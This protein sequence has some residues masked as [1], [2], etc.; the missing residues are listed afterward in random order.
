MAG[1]IEGGQ[2]AAKTNKARYGANF[3]KEIGSK[4]GRVKGIAKGWG[5][6]YE[7]ASRSGKI[8]GKMSR[9]QP[10]KEINDC[11]FCYKTGHTAYACDA[12]RA[13]VAAKKVRNQQNELERS[14]MAQIAR[15]WAGRG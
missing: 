2:A 1:T 12:R 13:A 4:G 11:T 3:Y 5:A 15:K 8:G 6:S 7:L 10:V 9:R 14:R